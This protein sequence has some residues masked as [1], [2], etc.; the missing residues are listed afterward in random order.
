MKIAVNTRLL[1]RNKLEGIGWFTYETLKRVTVQ[2]HEHEFYFIFDRPWDKH[3]IFA[4]NI[5][6]IYSGPQSRHPVLWYLWFQFT[7]P[8]LLNKIKPDIFLSPDGYLP[9]NSKH[10]TLAVVHDIAFE[11][12]PQSVPKL[13]AKYYRYFFPK[14]C[15][16]ADMLAT[17]SEYSKQDIIKTYGV[18]GE[19]IKVVYNGMNTAF[20]PI[21]EEQQEKTRAKW[22][23]EKQYFLFIGGLQPRKNLARLVRAYTIF[24]QKTS[25]DF[26]LVIV[27]KKAFLIE[28]LE[29]AVN[30]SPYK[31]DI[32]F[33]GHIEGTEVLNSIIGSSFAM[34]YVSIFEG[35]GIPCLEA[36]RCGTAVITSN[37][38]SMPEV[39][40]DAALYVDPFSVDSIA[41]KLT[42]LY[43]EEGLRDKL[44]EKGYAR[45]KEFSWQRTSE[46]L[47]VAIEELYNKK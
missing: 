38:S 11:H 9:L 16:Q 34:T 10:K 40:A 24:K 41:E 18:E 3:F 27:G 19:K 4:D 29:E 44:I 22:T 30:A 45:S 5:K 33:L 25:S 43:K 42:Q 7:I 35:F 26:K 32:L 17:V 23:D 39:C 31:E 13:V 6:P 20:E 28:E 37:T 1:L 46:L 2:H 47:W 36:M 21:T 15:K 8:R 14:F 12:F